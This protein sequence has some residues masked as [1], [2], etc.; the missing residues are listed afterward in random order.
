MLCFLTT[1]TV[2]LGVSVRQK[3]TLVHRL[4]QR[5]ELYSIAEAG[6][7]QALVIF[8]L[9]D[10]TPGFDTVTEFENKS[11]FRQTSMGQGTWT[12]SYKYEEDGSNVT[13]YGFIDE[14]SKINLNKARVNVIIN[15]LEN[16]ADLGRE[17]A[18]ELGHCIIDWRDADSCFQHAQY[19]AEDSDYRFLSKSYECKDGDFEVLEE[20]LLVKGMTEKIF[21]RIKDNI[22]IY[23]SGVININTASENVLAALDLDEDL[24]SKISSFR[25]GS[26][27]N[28][29]TDDDFVFINPGIIVTEL[30]SFY[31]LSGAE[32]DKLNE[33]VSKGLV[34]TKSNCFMIR[35]TARLKNKNQRAEI[36]TVVNREGQIK[37]WRCRY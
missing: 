29:G 12:V 16:T 20:V 6:I 15:L 13:K 2:Y 35:S 18:R 27:S 21:N 4:N 37:Y 8:K 25:K 5:A 17:Q 3:L 36:I 11:L 1:S 24:I 32:K 33:L 26:D 31:T 30:D 34:G 19:G 10:D 22:T 28:I 14:D 23:G 9:E 7:K